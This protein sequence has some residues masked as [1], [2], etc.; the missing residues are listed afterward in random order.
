MLAGAGTRLIQLLDILRGVA[1]FGTL[2]TNI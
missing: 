1:I 2:G